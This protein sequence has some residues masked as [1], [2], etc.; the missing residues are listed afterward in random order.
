MKLAEILKQSLLV[1][2]SAGCIML[3][4]TQVSLA[5]T[6]FTNPTTGNEYGLTDS[7]STWTDA[8]AT[9]QTLGGNLVTINDQAEQNWLISIFGG[10]ELFWIGLTDQ[11]NEG[12]FQWISGEPTSYTNWAFGEPN[13]LGG[14]ENYAHMNWTSAGRWNDVPNSGFSGLHRGIIERSVPAAVPTP[15]LLP[16]LIGMGIA[17]CRKRKPGSQMEV[18]ERA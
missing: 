14:N 11:S 5:V 3:G 2:G 18:S 4:T 6:F 8:Q 12:T 7:S 1:V 16:G 13:N 17:A 15:A 10:S 9:A